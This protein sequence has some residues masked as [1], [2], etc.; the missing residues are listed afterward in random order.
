MQHLHKF[1]ILH[2]NLKLDNILLTSNNQIKITDFVLARLE[3]Y[4]MMPYT[5][6]D[7]KERERSNREIHR[8]WYRA[9][10]ML[11]RKSYYANE[12]DIWS[13]GC[14]LAELALGAPLFK[15][16]NEIEYLFQVF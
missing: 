7:P 3:T 11:F 5:P 14:I 12:I 4:P 9:P 2:R 16:R 15:G 8:L 13:L 1:H 6:E 10:E